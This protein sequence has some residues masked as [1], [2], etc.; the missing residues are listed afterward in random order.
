[1]QMESGC[2]NLDHTKSIQTKYVRMFASVKPKKN[3]YEWTQDKLPY[4]KVVRTIWQMAYAN[5]C[6]W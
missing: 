3:E 1:M 2:S 5:M 6:Q 4:T